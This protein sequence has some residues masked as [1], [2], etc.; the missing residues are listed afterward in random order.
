MGNALLGHIDKILQDLP[1]EVVLIE[2]N[3]GFLFRDDVLKHMELRGMVVCAGMVLQ[4]RIEF[5]LK[6]PGVKLILLN[7]DF[8]NY[9]EDITA[10]ADRFEFLLSD[11]IEGYHT[12]TIIDA[13]LPVLDELFDG[14]SLFGLSKAET[15]K[16]VSDISSLIGLKDQ[17]IK[18][19]LLSEVDAELKKEMID[20]NL[21]SYKLA[22]LINLSFKLNRP[23]E[24]DE[25]IRRVNE[26]F[27]EYRAQS[28]K[29]TIN[30][31]ALKHPQNVCRILEHLDFNYKDKK[32]A[33]VVVDGMSIWQYRLIS[34]AFQGSKD[35]KTTLSWIPSITQLSR[36]AIFRGD[37]PEYEYSQSPQSEEK[38]WFNFWQ[39]KG[40]L[41][42][43]ISYQYDSLDEQMLNGVQKLAVVYKDLD[44]YMHGNCKDYLDL[45]G[46]TENWV[47]R[48]HIGQA[49]NTLL[50]LGFTIFLTTDHGNVEASGWRG[51]SAREKLGQRHKSGSRGE[52]HLEYSEQ[53]LFDE[54]V[55]NNPD[56]QKS[57]VRE[58]HAIYFKDNLS[59]SKKNQLVTHGGAH[60][61]EVVVPFVRIT[62]HE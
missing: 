12:P 34:S 23:N 43:E 32:V 49:I 28:Y 56:I 21:I 22:E 59:F 52:R 61:L 5:E 8:R 6:E 37:T 58:E 4:Q 54:F 36:Q 16:K 19:S 62:N 38:L 42:H 24:I 17:E 46:L 33:L 60:F 27:Q 20:W 55:K 47:K 1:S 41:K 35:E 10:V 9:L 18:K 2:N 11:Y 31:N 44:S 57:I 7:P 45:K 15:Q 25:I 26:V 29:Q 3:D 51:L 39:N 53:F 50:E 14:P 30:S 48:S 40:L 13:P